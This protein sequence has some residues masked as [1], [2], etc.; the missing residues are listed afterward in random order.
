[1][2]IRF[3]LHTSSKPPLKKAGNSVLIGLGT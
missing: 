1:V 2:Q 3:R